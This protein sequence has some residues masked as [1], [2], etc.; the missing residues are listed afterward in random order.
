MRT[1][2]QSYETLKI[3]EKQE[4]ILKYEILDVILNNCDNVNETKG[5]SGP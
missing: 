5:V 2:W 1:G 3:V 4:K